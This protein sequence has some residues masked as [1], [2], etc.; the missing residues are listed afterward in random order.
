[1]PSKSVK[2]MNFGFDFNAGRSERDMM[3]D[4]YKQQNSTIKLL[5]CHFYDE[6]DTERYKEA[7]PPL[8]H[9]AHQK[10]L[11]SGRR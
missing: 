4:W 10:L 3:S 1:M 8:Q 6:D 5:Y 9:V 11:C 7:L 2:K